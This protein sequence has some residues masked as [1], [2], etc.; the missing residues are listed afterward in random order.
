MPLHPGHDDLINY[1]VQLAFK[2]FRYKEPSLLGINAPNVHSIA[3]LFAEVVGVLA[4]SR[5]TVECRITKIECYF[6]TLF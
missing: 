6:Q 1:I 5:C 3:D 2:Q 4:Q